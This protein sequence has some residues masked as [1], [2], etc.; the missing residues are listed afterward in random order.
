MSD[1]SRSEGTSATSTSVVLFDFGGVLLHLNDPVEAFGLDGTV[2]DF[3]RRWLESPAVRAHETGRI[4]V[5]TFARRLVDELRLPWPPDELVARFD[6]WPDAVSAQTAAL[7]RSIPRSYECAIL[8]NTNARHWAAFDIDA[9]FD[10][11]IGR[12]FLSFESGHIKPDSAAF[13]QVVA[14]YGG[15]ASSILFFDDNPA[16]VEAAQRIGMRARLCAGVD[17]LAGLLA[18]EGIVTATTRQP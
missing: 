1:A 6:R 8:S 12:C 10:G 13:E 16:N 14:F 11:R 2:A 3:S 5:H 18:D 7:V 4:D 17:A 9:I 15:P